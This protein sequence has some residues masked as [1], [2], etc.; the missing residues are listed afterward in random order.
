MPLIRLRRRR[1]HRDYPTVEQ[2]LNQVK[3][4]A[5]RERFRHVR[6]WMHSNGI[7]NRMMGL[8]QT[9]TSPYCVHMVGVH[10]EV[11]KSIEEVL[12]LTHEA[13]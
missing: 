8:M 5:D 10:P 11:R 4:Q 13:A 1:Y 6:Q 9:D 3:Q 2:M 12:I 7:A